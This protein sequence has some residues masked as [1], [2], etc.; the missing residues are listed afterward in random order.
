[1]S[2]DLVNLA[3]IQT[4]GDR[5]GE[6]AMPSRPVLPLLDTDRVRARLDQPISENSTQITRIGLE[7]ALWMDRWLRAYGVTLDI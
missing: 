2:H 6:S 1:M 4:N 7:I 3:N 5:E